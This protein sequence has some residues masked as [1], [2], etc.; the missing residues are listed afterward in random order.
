MRVGFMFAA[1][2]PGLAA[3]GLSQSVD[4]REIWNRPTEP[5]RIPGNVYYVG[6]E[7]L[8]AF[9][10]TTSEG[11]VLI[12]GALPESADQIAANIGRLGFRVADVKYLLISHAHLDHAGGLA[13]L[14]ALSGAR[15]L[16]SAGD[17]PELESGR[18]GYRKS[19]DFPPVKV[20]RVIQHGERLRIGDASLTAHLTPGHTKGCT[21][22]SARIAHRQRP[23]E[24]MFA[25]S[26][27]VAGQ[28]LVN[29]DGYPN[30]VA[31][32]RTSFA[33]LKEVKADMFV[34]FHSGSFDMAE[35]RQ[36][37][38]AG[39][40]DAFIDPGELQRRVQAAETAFEQE[41]ARQSGGGE[42]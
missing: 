41:L 26:L 16:A 8:G 14:K 32:F 6:T 5:F 31:D 20:D 33:R 28:P 4:Q 19:W 23:L 27:T 18:I 21:S 30:A 39:D 15:L 40:P 7:A 2:A 38:A 25:C 9:L 1:V 17:R 35:K 22:W 24:V 3:S 42:P 29:D 34:G 36:R 13:R 12:D 11:H 10:I 37:L